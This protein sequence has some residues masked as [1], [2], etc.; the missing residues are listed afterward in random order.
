V[1]PVVPEAK[2]AK[3]A[4][5]PVVAPAPVAE[6]VETPVEGDAPAETSFEDELAA[7]QTQLGAIREA[8]TQALAALKRLAKRHGAEMKD[9]RKN[10]R[11]ARKETDGTEPRRPNNFEIPVAVSDELSAFF[12]GGKS[13]TM[14]RAQVNKAMSEYIKK[15]SLGQG[16]KINP[17]AALKKLLRIADGDDV[18]IFNIQK[19]LKAHYPAAATKA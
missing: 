11:K 2:K 14:S 10:R 6:T 15:N 3:K 9:A 12:G 7:A 19:Y 18:T 8:A 16:Q 1:A 13:A 5:A 17:D 4:T